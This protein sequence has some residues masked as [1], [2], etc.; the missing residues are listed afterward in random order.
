MLNIIKEPNP[1][2]HKRA[3]EV[4][5]KEINDELRSYLDKMIVTMRSSNGV[6]LASPQVGDL[7]RMLVAEIDFSG[8]AK[9]AIKM[10][11][12]EIIEFSGKRKS[13]EGCLSIP[14]LEQKVDRKTSIQVKYLDEYGT[15]VIKNF[16]GFSAV[17]IQ[18]EIDHLDGITL[19]DH[20]SRVKKSKYLKK[21]KN[22][23][24]N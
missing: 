5:V 1:L 4:S 12:P 22:K 2:L 20:S 3:K 16:E 19:L 18:H 11:N 17:I 13:C 10:I 7:R 15:E 23:L 9:R 6:G 21:I 14:G 8:H 24:L